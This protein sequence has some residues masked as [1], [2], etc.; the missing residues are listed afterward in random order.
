VDLDSWIPTLNSDTSWS[1]TSSALRRPPSVTHVASRT[2]WPTRTSVTCG[3][4]AV[5][6]A[7][8]CSG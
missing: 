3:R 7:E 6:W 2:R 8:W 1:W 4:T 5:A